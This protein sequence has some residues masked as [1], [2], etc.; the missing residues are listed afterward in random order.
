MEERLQLLATH[1]SARE[2]EQGAGARDDKQQEEHGVPCARAM[3]E[4]REMQLQQVSVC[5]TQF[6]GMCQANR[7]G[8]VDKYML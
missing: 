8:C 2:A 3:D 5:M 4:A 6:F 1:S 7:Q